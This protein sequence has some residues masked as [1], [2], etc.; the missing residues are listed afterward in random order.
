MKREHAVL[1]IFALS[2]FSDAVIGRVGVST[3][4]LSITSLLYVLKEAVEI[5][6][7]RG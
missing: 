3:W 6:Q 1:L 5:H 2:I 4:L 7:G